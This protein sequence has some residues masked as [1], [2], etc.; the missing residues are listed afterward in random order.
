VG[1]LDHSSFP[2]RPAD[3]PGL[4]EFDTIITHQYGNYWCG[5]IVGEKI[6][7]SFKRETWWDGL[8]KIFLRTLVKG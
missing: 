2:L 7:G 6:T 5:D 4:E 8:I 1:T 3:E